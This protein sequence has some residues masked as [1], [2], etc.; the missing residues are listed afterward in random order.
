MNSTRRT[1]TFIGAM[2]LA[3]A[4]STGYAGFLSHSLHL[5]YGLGVLALAA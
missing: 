1:Q 2:V 5:Y 4:A 3:A